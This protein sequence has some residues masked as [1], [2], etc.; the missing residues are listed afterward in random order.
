MICSLVQESKSTNLDG[1]SKFLT[2]PGIF[3]FTLREFVFVF[4]GTLKNYFVV[5]VVGFG[6]V[7]VWVLVFF[8]CGFYGVWGRVVFVC[9]FLTF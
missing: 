8:V 5:V 2:F 6:C 1:C 3:F 9:V 7:V 4:G